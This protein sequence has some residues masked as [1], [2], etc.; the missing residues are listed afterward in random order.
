MCSS[1]GRAERPPLQPQMGCPPC[2]STG[3]TLLTACCRPPPAA[4]P[5]LCNGTEIQCASGRVWNGEL[6]CL[7]NSKAEPPAFSPLGGGP[8]R[9]PI[10]AGA[11]PS[12]LRKGTVRPTGSLPACVISFTSTASVA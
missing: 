9:S 3:R 7:G 8:G 6:I 1:G 5:T 2:S 4:A 11:Q 12:G 10:T